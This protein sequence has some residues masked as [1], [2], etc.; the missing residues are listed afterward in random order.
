MTF[1]HRCILRSVS[2]SISKLVVCLG[3][4]FGLVICFRLAMGLGG[5][6]ITCIPKKVDNPSTAQGNHHRF[7]PSNNDHHSI[8]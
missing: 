2:L 8:T 5:T 4:W 1:L 6:N 3:S 7:L